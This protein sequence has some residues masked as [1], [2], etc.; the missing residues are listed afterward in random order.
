MRMW[1]CTHARAHKDPREG[2]K[3]EA[4]SWAF[5]HPSVHMISLNK[6]SGPCCLLSKY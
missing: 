1:A 4:L 2:D 3:V 5:V 6:L